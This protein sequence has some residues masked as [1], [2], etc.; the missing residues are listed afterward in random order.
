M[1]RISITEFN[2]LLQQAYEY[3]S[4]NMYQPP[5]IDGGDFSK[6]CF[7]VALEQ[8]NNCYIIDTDDIPQFQI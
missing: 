5:E 1:K 2:R 3:I 7:S 6:F 8:I 4:A